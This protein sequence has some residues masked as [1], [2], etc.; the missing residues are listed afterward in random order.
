MFGKR[1]SSVQL[2]SPVTNGTYWVR[3]EEITEGKIGSKW[4]LRF[5]FSYENNPEGVPNDFVLFDVEPDS[6]PE[7][8]LW[9]QIRLERIFRC[10][11][12]DGDLTPENYCKWIGKQ[13]M[14]EIGEGKNGYKEV[15]RFIF[16]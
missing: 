15:K 4:G 1:N 5:K 12:L 10:F 13:G 9:F 2:C 7:K 6:D 11:G 8:V 16:N 3:L 14:V